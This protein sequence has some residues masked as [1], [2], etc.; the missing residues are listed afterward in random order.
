MTK[1]KIAITIDENLLNLVETKLQEGLFR[2]RS[3][4]I[5]YSIKKMLEEKKN[6]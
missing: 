3:H 5:E 6:E 1:Q 2:N 4:F